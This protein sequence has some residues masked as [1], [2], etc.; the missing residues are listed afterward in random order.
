MLE[1]ADI[2]TS[3]RRGREGARADEM[4]EPT[5][6]G[7]Q[8]GPIVKGKIDDGQPGGGK[9]FVELLA[10]LEISGGHE[11]GCEFL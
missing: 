3:I 9:S 2:L 6:M 7:M 4:V 5:S 10:G 8:P 11:Q 1:P